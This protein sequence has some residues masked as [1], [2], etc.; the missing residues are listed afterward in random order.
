MF[1]A[2]QFDLDP[3]LQDGYGGTEFLNSIDPAPISL[4]PPEKINTVGK[5]A[6]NVEVGILHNQTFRKLH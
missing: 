2:F 1:L 3:C 5:P 6:T 4:L